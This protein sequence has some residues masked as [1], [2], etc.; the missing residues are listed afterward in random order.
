MTPSITKAP[1]RWHNSLIVRVIG[2]CVILFLCLMGM[3]YAMTQV[4]FDQTAKVRT[5]DIARSVQIYL[6]E[7][8]EA[9]PDLE[10][11]SDRIVRQ[12]DGLNDL[13]IRSDVNHQPLSIEHSVDETGAVIVVA[14]T[15][16][17]SGEQPFRLEARFDLG[18]EPALLRVFQN[19]YL[20]ALT[21]AFIVVLGLMVYFI[22][23]ALRP[24]QE[25]S[26]SCAR[27][28]EGHLQEVEVRKNYGEVLALE[29]TFNGMVASLRDKEMVETK[30]RQTQRLSSLGTLAAGIAHD[31]RNP[32]NAIKLLSSHAESRLE[33]DANY[34]STAR[35]V[36]TIRSEVDRLEEIVSGFLSLAK[37]HE[38]QREP[39]GIDTILGECVRLVEKDAEAREVKLTSELRAGGVSLIVD[40]KH[41]TR[42][43]LN[44]I[45]NAMEA[46][47]PG[48]RVRL[49]SRVTD[50]TCQIEVRDD[51][52]GLPDAES[53][54]VF[55]PYFTTKATGTGLGLSIT[56]GIV[57]EHGGTITLMSTE[58][59]GSQ[60]LITLPL[61]TDD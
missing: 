13:T 36:N 1:S 10:N 21:A 30:L 45:I 34:E 51:G 32:L 56:R 17:E 53:D 7:N 2:L 46:C 43:I 60:A 18:P 58:G 9:E 59:Q 48:G 39:C 33:G 4:Y 20:V 12:F 27:I 37:E 28:S 14:S 8:V 6:D 54:R 15:S 26:E 3:V 55:D 35:Q 44:V 57:E 16:I 25:L 19:R 38:L 29:Q 41:W 61:E 52:P 50:S 47:P 11:M 24:L 31:L 49:F 40:P 5:G 22:Y 42:A 23:N